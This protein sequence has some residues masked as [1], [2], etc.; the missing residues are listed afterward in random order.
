MPES[1]KLISMKTVDEH[2]NFI[3]AKVQVL[4]KK[5]AALLKENASL[6]NELRTRLEKEKS[7]LKKIDEFEIQIGIL[8]ASAGNMEDKEKQDFEKRINHYI[9][10]ID[11]C[12][13][14]LKN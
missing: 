4:L 9:K 14:M 5:H 13:S 3:N 6:S 2:L 8:K 7:L 10:D 12:M 11:K 1:E